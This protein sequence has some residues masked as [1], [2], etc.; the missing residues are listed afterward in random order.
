MVWGLALAVTMIGALLS[1]SC[2]TQSTPASTDTSA[3]SAKPY[4]SLVVRGNVVGSFDPIVAGTPNI[5][6]A[7]GAAVFDSLVDFSPEG[8]FRPAIAERWE[9]SADGMTHTFYIRKGV[10]FHDGSDL[11]GADVKFSLERILSP[12][13][14]NIDTTIWRDEIAGIDLKDDYTVVFRL[15][16]S[17][18]E[19]L[20]GFNDFGSSPAILPKKYIETKGVDYFRKNPVGSGPWKVVK[21]ELG[22]RAELEAVEDHWRETPKFK[23]ITVLNVDDE[24]TKV[25]MLQTGE[26]DLADISPDSVPKLKSAGLRIIGHDGAAQ[27]FMGLYYDLTQPAKYAM[28]DVRVRKALSL[29]INRQEMADKILGGYAEPSALFY[30]RPTGYFWDANLLKPDPYDPQQ[31][32]KVLADAGFPNG[33]TTKVWNQVGTVSANILNEAAAGYWRN[34]G[35]TAELVPVESAILRSMRSPVTKPEMFNTIYTA[36]NTGG[37][38]QFEKMVTAYHS[39]KGTIQT[40][41]NAKLDEL[42]DRVPATK[43]PAERK[44]LALE[45]AVMAKNEYSILAVLDIRT[46]L[47]LGSKVGSITLTKGS[48]AYAYNLATLSHAK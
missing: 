32:K 17:R 1:T 40:H 13:S 44:K 43:D 45:A 5:Y 12:E 15:K 24:A 36:A 9:I 28:G 22:A 34:I 35:I 18:V 21:L 27:Y 30:A 26:L 37:V 46:V 39:K 3:T 11:T 19:L 6:Q 8:Q 31:A 14:T 2:S 33:F 25:A 47:A 20:K 4:G 7:L 38:F 16:Q 10:K 29:A 42:I 48:G 41:S 23:N